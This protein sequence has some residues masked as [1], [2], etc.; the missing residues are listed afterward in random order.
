MMQPK[1]PAGNISMRNLVPDN[2]LDMRVARTSLMDRDPRFREY[3]MGESQVDNEMFQNMI[4]LGL[5]RSVSRM[6]NPVFARHMREGFARGPVKGEGIMST[7]KLDDEIRK[8]MDDMESMKR[9]VS[10][11]HLTLPTKA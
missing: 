9:P 5:P 4:D 3:I 8:M 11:T 1:T 2:E 7:S 10:Y 6:S